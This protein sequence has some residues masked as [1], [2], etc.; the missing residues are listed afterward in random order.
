MIKPLAI[1]VIK[2]RKA[3]AIYDL[4]AYILYNILYNTLRALKWKGSLFNFQVGKPYNNFDQTD[5]EGKLR[6]I[7]W[8]HV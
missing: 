1:A 8:E 7:V 6:Q 2:V 5:A 3:E 4:F